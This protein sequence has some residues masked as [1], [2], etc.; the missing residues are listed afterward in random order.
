MVE[1]DSVKK[2]EG[3]GG[4]MKAI[5]WGTLSFKKTVPTKA[6]CEGGGGGDGG[7]LG[8]ILS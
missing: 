2:P 4:A 3:V 6:L 5:S 7:V 1:T 8:G